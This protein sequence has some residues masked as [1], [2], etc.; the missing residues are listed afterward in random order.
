MKLFKMKNRKWFVVLFGLVLT[1]A[2]VFFTAYLKQRRRDRNQ[3]WIAEAVYKEKEEKWVRN[4]FH[5]L[6]FESPNLGLNPKD[7]VS[8]LKFDGVRTGKFNSIAT[9]DLF[10]SVLYMDMESERYDFE[11]GMEGI[12]SNLVNEMNGS[13]LEYEFKYGESWLPYAIAEGEFRVDSE[14]I[15]LKAFL[16][17]YTTSKKKNNLRSLV[18]IGSNTNQNAEIIQRSIESIDLDYL[19]NERNPLVKYLPKDYRLKNFDPNDT[20]PDIETEER[21]KRLRQLREN[22]KEKKEFQVPYKYRE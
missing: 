18:I 21:L 7:E 20:I 1:L 15:L 5:G 16:S 4:S 2:S 22:L 10:Y 12:L 8:E 13:D 3:N 11:K 9:G 17:F 19:K 14:P 6:I